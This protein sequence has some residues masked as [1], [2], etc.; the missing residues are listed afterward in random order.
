MQLVARRRLLAAALPAGVGGLP[1]ER[2]Q[3]SEE[4]RR[5]ERPLEE[6]APGRQVPAV[7]DDVGGVAG[8][9]QR[10]QPAVR[11]GEALGELR[12]VSPGMITSLTRTSIALPCRAATSSASS[13]VPVR[14]TV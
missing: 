12:P 5:V 11:L 13:G 8:E 14:R 6:R 10:R 4:G 1:D 7:P 9:E 3:R 2:P